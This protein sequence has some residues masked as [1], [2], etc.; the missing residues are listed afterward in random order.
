MHLKF[1]HVTIFVNI[2]AYVVKV[3][4]KSALLFGTVNAQAE[5]YSRKS[6]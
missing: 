2:Q 3:Y 6:F 5:N 4:L 1:S